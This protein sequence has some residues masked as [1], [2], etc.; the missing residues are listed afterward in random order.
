MIIKKL[1]Q[2][3][4]QIR[5]VP[6]DFDLDKLIGPHYSIDPD[7][8]RLKEVPANKQYTIASYSSS[9]ENLSLGGTRK[10]TIRVRTSRPTSQLLRELPNT[11]QEPRRY[12]YHNFVLKRPN[13]KTKFIYNYE[14]LEYENL[15][16]NFKELDLPSGLLWDYV[17]Y[18]GT[19]YSLTGDIHSIGGAVVV[20][21]QAPSGSGPF[22][23]SAKLSDDDNEVFDKRNYTIGAEPKKYMNNYF[24]EFTY[25]NI[26]EDVQ[27]NEAWQTKQKN[28]FLMYN[29]KKNI[30]YL[31]NCVV[32]NID[33]LKDTEENDTVA[34]VLHE[35]ELLKFLFLFIKREQPQ[36]VQFNN[37]I[38][39]ETVSHKTWDV[40][41]WLTSEDFSQLETQDDEIILY[42]I[43]DPDLA[44]LRRYL[45]RRFRKILA[46]GKIKQYLK[47]NVLRFEDV[48]ENKKHCQSSVIGYKVEK[49]LEG[50]ENIIQTYY[51]EGRINNFI[52]N[53]ICYDKRYFYRVSELR[54]VTGGQYSY[55]V[56]R[57][58]APRFNFINFSS[59]PSLRVVETPVYEFAYR[60]S[61]PPLYSPHVI[62]SNEQFVKNKIL[63]FVSDYIGNTVKHTEVIEKVVPADTNFHNN[64]IEADFIDS[65]NL[66]RYFSRSNTGNFEVFRIEN[67]PENYEDFSDGFL[68]IFGNSEDISTIDQE[69]HSSFTDYIEH[70]K[71][72]YYM[73]RSVDHHGNAGKPSSVVEA[74]LIEDSDEVLLRYKAYDIYSAEEKYSTKKTL[75]K[76]IQILPSTRHLQILENQNTIDN[77]LNVNPEEE[78][79]A[80]GLSGEE[81]LWD[82]SNENKY[83]KLRVTSKSTGKKFDLNLRFKQKLKIK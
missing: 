72:Y 17:K 69:K 75:R 39:N 71:T 9:Y 50:S 30:D 27:F 44:G 57:S 11:S 74:Y 6:T 51:L 65:D 62:V 46:L 77:L 58:L 5:Q 56:S 53:Q 68:G 61:V 29:E 81:S 18:F 64:L 45:P 13:I 43:K 24:R 63:F 80:L 23:V 21:H 67:K 7:T 33:I 82:Y 54:I 32:F 19:S 78:V 10:E 47:D 49:Y 35:N 16:R 28:I 66:A 14:F 12:T 38:S 40:L 79:G 4:T 83:I 15:T 48:I 59:S 70:E 3:R 22:L 60:V 20:P 26:S 2:L 36:M 8:L 25:R 34:K 76:Y 42:D 37:Q 41:E 1:Q 52:D 31:P 73:F 55:T